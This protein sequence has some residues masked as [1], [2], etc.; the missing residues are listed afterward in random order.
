MLRTPDLT[1]EQAAVLLDAMDLPN[2]AANYVYGALVR[3]AA[4]S[5]TVTPD[6]LRVLVDEAKAVTS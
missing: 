1:D 5:V 3:A 2:A 4:E 6:R